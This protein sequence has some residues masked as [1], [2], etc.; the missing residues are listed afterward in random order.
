MEQIKSI[1]LVV[2]A[3]VVIVSIVEYVSIHG[4]FTLIGIISLVLILGT[5]SYFIVKRVIIWYS[6]KDLKKPKRE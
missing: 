2:L 5:A 6:K 4:Q 3:I 1:I